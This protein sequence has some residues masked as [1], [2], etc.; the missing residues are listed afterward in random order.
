MNGNSSRPMV[1]VMDV[2]DA[3]PNIQNGKKSG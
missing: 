3:D 1:M 2:L